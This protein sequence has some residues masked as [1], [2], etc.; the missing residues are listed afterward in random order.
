[1]TLTKFGRYEIKDVLGQGGMAAVYKA[2]DPR[3]D[4]LVALK[5]IR[6]NFS[7]DKKF[8]ERFLNEAKTIAG[9]E[10][11]AILP[12]HDF[13]QDEPTNKLYLVM[14]L[15]PDVLHRRLEKKGAIPLEDA[16]LIL[17]RLAAA[18]NT[19]HNRGIVHRD[20]KP[21]NILLDEDGT[22]FLADFGLAAP[23]DKIEA[24]FLPQSYGGSPF[25]MAPEQWRGE[26]A[27]PFTDVYQLGVTLFE[28]L[29]GERPFPEDNLELLMDRHMNSQIP[30][31]RDLNPRLPKAIQPILEKAMA[32]NPLDRHKSC[33]ELAQEV[34]NLLHPKL[35][36]NRYEIKEELQ[37]GRLTAVYL[38]HDLFEKRDVALKVLKQALIPYPSYQQRFQHQRHLLLNLPAHPTI[39]SIYDVDQYEGQPYIAM[40]FVEG[41]SLRERFRKERVFSMET[42]FEL[43]R[44]LAQ[45]LD[46]LHEANLTHGDINLGNVLLDEDGQ[47]YLTDFHITAV[48]E[49]TKAVLDQKS[50]L[51]YMPYM[52]PEQWR[53]ETITSQTDVYQFGVM[54]FEMLT[55]QL[56]FTGASAEELRLAIENDPLPK[57][58]AVVPDLPKQFDTI[59]ARAL[60]KEANARFTQ[61]SEVINRL[62]L[63]GETH[64]FDTL[65]EQ[66][67]R[68]YEERQWE[69]AIDAYREAQKL[70]PE[71]LAVKDALER[72]RRR[73]QDSGIFYQSDVAIEEKRWRDAAYFL[74]RASDTKEKKEKLQFVR[75]MI[76]AEEQYEA[77]KSAMQDGQWFKAQ[78][79]LDEADF[80]APN[81]E[82]VNQLLAQVAEE[83]QATLQ[84]ART[85]VAQQRYDQALALL[86]PL[87]EHKTAV[88]L[89]QEIAIKRDR[90]RRAGRWRFFSSRKGRTWGGVG[91]TAV[92][93]IMTALILLNNNNLSP[94]DCFLS[95]EPRLHVQNEG[96][97]HVV[98]YGGSPASLP[99]NWQTMELWVRWGPPSLPESCRQFILEGERVTV[100]WES[101]NRNVIEL[102]DGEKWVVTLE[103]SPSSADSDEIIVS[104]LH[105]NQRRD[106]A[107]QLNFEQ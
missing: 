1:M 74:E 41:A 23:V 76:Q 97:D 34:A 46:C 93:L 67:D 8:Q 28:M 107:F 60:A 13:G 100:L 16:S 36:K 86:A 51:S 82:D 89:R 94:D 98:L 37:H 18:L 63:A 15:M 85:A 106:F 64:I 99:G 9:L 49:L 80:L 20:I 38:A 21:P 103:M 91:L 53:G 50:P 27:G 47:C 6:K 79:L 31:A 92:V 43:A 70:R 11:R 95:A 73:K 96:V 66:G 62:I 58:T 81:Y 26:P 45:A 3:M 10:H 59:L 57:V 55:G 83:I 88:A 56:P 87:G 65:K 29:T 19:A 22:V 102:V 25:Y 75:R 52:A 72:A 14:R 4:R 78:K 39:V 101:Q 32:K 69:A 105:D 35:I 61:A 5:I 77:G 84:Q 33:L 44:C 71:D 7:E 17:N 54:I 48:A 2:Y 12:V 68:Y 30:L 40:Q 24:G 90:V 104:L 42:V